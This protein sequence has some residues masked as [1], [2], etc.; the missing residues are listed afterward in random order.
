MMIYLLKSLLMIPHR[1][2]DR[3]LVWF[4]GVFMQKHVASIFFDRGFHPGEIVTCECCYKRQAVDVAHIYWRLG[5]NYIDPA[6]L[7]YMCRS[8]HYSFDVRHRWSR[9]DIAKRVADT[10]ERRKEVIALLGR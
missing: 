3:E 7:I 8:C 9:D 5:D 10:R 4:E 1:N 2:N 6:H